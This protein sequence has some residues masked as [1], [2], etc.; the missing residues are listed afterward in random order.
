MKIRSS[1]LVACIVVVPLI[2]MF[3][4]RVPPAA[5]TAV[6]QWLR[7]VA[8]G[9]RSVTPP[10]PSQAAALPPAG[11]QAARPAITAPP[12]T[13]GPRIV[14][15]TA[16]VPIPGPGNDGE[17]ESLERLRALGAV[18]IECRPVLGAGG[19]IASCRVPVDGAGQL[20]RV[21]QATGADPAAAAAKLLGDVNAW[22][23]GTT[24]GPPRTIRF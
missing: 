22:Q 6:A 11:D 20:E 18:T 8:G 14:P 13:E 16:V 12:A 2:A 24:A 17:R 5:R 7:D 10:I 15:V 9:S 23:R 1:L 4:H 19:H 3:S 21:F